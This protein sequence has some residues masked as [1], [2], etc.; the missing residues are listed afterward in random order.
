MVAQVRARY[1]QLVTHRTPYEE[2]ARDVAKV[3]IPSLFPPQGSNAADPLPQPFQ[4]V[5]A[6][7]TNN[8]AS[9]LLLALLPPG[10]SFFRL[11][12]AEKVIAE[13][14]ARDDGEDVRGK[15][16][17]ALSLYE[18]RVTN[19]LETAGSRI[20]IYESLR[21]VLAAGNVLI[22][23]M[24]KGGMRYF[25]LDSYVV[26]R[27]G[28]GNV[29]E[30]IVKECLD[31]LTLPD[32]VAELVEAPKYD[33]AGKCENPDV[34]LYTRIR[35]TKRGW[36][37]TQEVDG[38]PVPKATSK[39]P[40]DKCPWL[41]LRY[42]RKAGEHYGR[43]YNDELIGDLQSLE[44][45]SMSLVDF[46]AVASRILH[47]VKPGGMT[48]LEDVINAKSGDA[49]EGVADDIG[50][51][52]SNKLADFQ[53]VQATAERIETRLEKAFLLNSSVQ[54]SGERVTAEE[55]RYVAQELEQGLGGI[56]SIL[57]Q[58]LQRPLVVLELAQLARDKE[59]PPLPKDTVKPE[60]ITGL[61]ALG[62]TSELMKLDALV[63]G[64]SQTFG[65]EAVSEYMNVGAF[66]TRRAAALAI[67]TQGLVRSEDEVQ[68]QRQQQARQNL[69]EKLGP[70]ALRQQAA[71]GQSQGGE[72]APAD[73]STDTTGQ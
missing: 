55:I 60:I 12:M 69:V 29:L 41:A 17:Q 42:T 48:R 24:T 16:E 26:V 66:I 10:N 43:S 34:E 35:R 22:H 50:L 58:E 47:L 9:K 67:D 44:L 45:L 57:A 20:I 59:L 8:L 1:N 7:G 46:G 51:L 64:I 54:R 13:L 62:R 14:Q 38:V 72:A 31:R 71:M 23:V 27:D 28:S 63:T 15:L 5:G 21:Q 18:K 2:R 65:P 73:A 37:E 68:Q 32:N 40:L 33:S 6:R 61:D 11:A 70:E 52:S 25:S 36:E 56:Y 49:I 19:A 4:S 30:I 39:Y 53:V 3:T